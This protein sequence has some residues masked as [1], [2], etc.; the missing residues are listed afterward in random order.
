MCIY[1]YIYMYI[2]RRP[3]ADNVY[4]YIYIYIYIGHRP[5]QAGQAGRQEGGR[6]GHVIVEWSRD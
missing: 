5:P 1:I 6:R 3:P 2:G 4:I